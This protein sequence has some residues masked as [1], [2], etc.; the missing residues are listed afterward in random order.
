MPPVRS[1]RTAD[2]G[3]DRL[4]RATDRRAESVIKAY[5]AAYGGAHERSIGSG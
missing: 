2:S 5:L 3:P 4:E 1:A